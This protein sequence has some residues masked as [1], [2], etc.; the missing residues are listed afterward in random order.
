ML[1]YGC[2]R[3]TRQKHQRYH[4]RLLGD[5]K[6][7]YSANMTWALRSLTE[8]KFDIVISEVDLDDGSLIKLKQAG[9]LDEN[10]VYLIVAHDRE[11]NEPGRGPETAH[12]LCEELGA[13]MVLFSPF[14]S[15]DV[16]VLVETYRAWA[17]RA[18]DPL[19]AS[20]AAAAKAVRDRDYASTSSARSSS[21]PSTSPR[22]RRSAPC[23]SPAA[24]STRRAGCCSR[25]SVFRR[26]TR[27]AR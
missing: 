10:E 2:E 8:K 13:H 15:E 17:A 7:Y 16:R 26:S 25:R 9:G 27:I 5:F 23:G 12:A 19:R 20:L 18:G 24:I 22:C 1:H 4:I 11:G 21:S 6:T 14:N 3:S